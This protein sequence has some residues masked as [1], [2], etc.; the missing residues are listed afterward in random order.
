MPSNEED[1]D[2]TNDD[3]AQ[4]QKLPLA[5]ALSTVHPVSSSSDS[6]TV[7]EHQAK[8]SPRNERRSSPEHD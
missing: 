3:Q 8:T 7:E 6:D 5:E 2:W 4:E 1:P